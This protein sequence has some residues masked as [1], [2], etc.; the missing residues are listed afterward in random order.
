M[1]TNSLARWETYSPV[2][3]GLGDLFNRLDAFTDS[4][5]TNYPPYNIVKVDDTTQQ[6][7]IALAGFSR[8]EIEVAVERNVLTV[9]TIRES[10]D[11]REYS[12]KG[13]AQRTFARNWQLSDDAVV[14][15]VEYKDGLLTISIAKEIPESQKRRLLP[16]S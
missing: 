9:K 6:L 16:I 11:G 14:G 13:L 12:Y 4:A 10:T 7:E 2:S 1:P 3:L 8:E 15:D 5:A